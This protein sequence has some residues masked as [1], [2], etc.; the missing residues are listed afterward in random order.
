MPDAD[1][2]DNDE[3]HK[4]ISAQVMPPQGD[5][6]VCARVFKRVRKHD[7]M[8]IGNKA[9]PHVVLDSIVSLL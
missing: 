4:F 1:D 5:L 2:F 3:Y 8:L 6:V 9:N 7:G